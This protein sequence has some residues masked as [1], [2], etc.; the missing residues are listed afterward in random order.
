MVKWLSHSY[1]PFLL[2]AISMILAIPSLW[3]GLILDDYFHKAMIQGGTL[4]GE[5]YKPTLNIFRFLDGN[6]AQA[7]SLMDKG[8]I[9]WWTLGN[10]KSSFW[11]PITALTHWLDYRLWPKFPIIMHF[12][13]L[14]W[15]GAVVIIVTLFYRRFIIAAPWVA[16]LAALL[17]AID[18]AHAVPIAWL[19]NRN[20]LIALFFGVAALLFHDQWRR[21]HGS[22]AGAPAF[23][24]FGMALLSKESA[25]AFCAYLFAYAV[26]IE[27]SSWWKRASSLAPYGFVVVV[28]RIFYRAAGY[29][30]WGSKFYTD[31]LQAPFHFLKKI[32][33]QM[34]ILLHGQWFFPPSEI[35]VLASAKGKSIFWLCSVVFFVVL[36]FLFLP[37]GQSLYKS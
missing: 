7:I 20:A 21:K 30:A 10:V 18:D 32:F 1:L 33:I 36:F 3:T 35:F 23:L 24:C 22:F 5:I 26:F 4:F 25:I 16:G 27:Q 17:Y 14:L 37:P 12:H 29:G 28:W 19:A 11:R 8:L 2:A 6:P 13:S 31:P 34:P 15:L 9:P